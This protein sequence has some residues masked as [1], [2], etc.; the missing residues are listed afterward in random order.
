MTTT[1][2]V[3][4]PCAPWCRDGDNGRHELLAAQ[5]DGC[6]ADATELP[7]TLEAPVPSVF[8]EDPAWIPAFVEV[9]P[10]RRWGRAAY[11][12]VSVQVQHPGHCFNLTADD[13]RGLA[14][15]L[16]RYA[17]LIDG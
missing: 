5:L 3:T 9:S 11:L 4:V 1:E 2:V 14:G 10:T 15:I 17:A 13:A 7:L 16:T 12:H 6:R 8:T